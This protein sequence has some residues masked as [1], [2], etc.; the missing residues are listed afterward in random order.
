MYLFIINPR[1]GGGAGGRTWHTVEALMKERSLPFMSLFT[2]SVEGAEALVLNTL[3]HREDWK[4]VIVIGGDGTLHSILGALCGK[5]IPMGVIPAGSGNDTARGFGIPLS[6]EA[7]LEAALSERYIE[8]DLLSG[9]NGLTVTAVA[10]GFDAQVA[11]NVNAS[12]YKRL[13]NAIGAG[14]LAYIIGI[15]HTLMTFKPC[16]VSVVCDGTEHAFE[17]AWLVSICNL[18]SYGGGLLICPQAKADDGQLDVCVVHGCSRGQLLRLFPTV[19]K[20]KH[21]ALPFVSMLRGRS[22]AV[23][24]AEARPAIGDGESLGKGPLAVRCEPGALR[25]LSPLAADSIQLPVDTA[26]ACGSNG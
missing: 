24:F 12:R 15:L 21:V 8:A 18:P 9:A 6:I 13:C 17:K 5:D 26:A 14:Q 23:G 11:E 2:H 19:L 10:N 1:S 7:A 3:K 4:A 25:V 20:G 16:R 22:V